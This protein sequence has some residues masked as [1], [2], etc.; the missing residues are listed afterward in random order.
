MVGALEEYLAGEPGL[1]VVP[2][3]ADL[4]EKPEAIEKE[5]AEALLR[6][7]IEENEAHTERVRYIL[8]VMLERKKIL[9]QIDTKQTDNGKFL[10]YEY[11][12]SG[13]V[14]IIC[15]PLLKLEQV[16]E[17]QKEVVGLL[18]TKQENASPQESLEKEGAEGSSTNSQT[19]ILPVPEATFS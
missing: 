2:I 5:S 16:G 9:T 15:D 11:I 12:K 1:A 3:V 17:V 19:E 13:D 14:L 4:L 7:L 10:I 18:G 6:R 8:A